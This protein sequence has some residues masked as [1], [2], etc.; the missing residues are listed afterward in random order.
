MKSSAIIKEIRSS[1][2]LSQSEL[3]EKLGVSFATV[4]RWEKGR[5][6]PS[7]IALNAVKS[8]CADSSIDFSQFEGNHYVSSNEI[9]TLYH[10]SKSGI[11]G[12]IAPTS[13]ARCDFGRGFYMGTDRNQ[14]LTLIC[15]YREAKIYTLTMNLSG[16]K[17]LDL[18]VGLDWA[19]LVAYNRGK[20]ETVRH[21]SI[22][23]RFADLSKDC[24]LIIGYIADDR[25]FVVLDRFFNGEITDLAL[26]N[27]LSALQLGRQYVA[28]T[29]KA[30]S[31][32]K[33]LD[34]QEIS[35]DDRDRLKLEG[36]ANR[37]KGIAMAEEIC[38][39]YRREGRFFDEILKAGG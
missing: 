28:L 14:P 7:Q 6:E 4:N 15:N 2:G 37:S 20:M 24:D 34:E 30:C 35:A 23:D 17:I 18:E 22:Y 9:I 27:S 12:P 3:A 5:C 19:L 11:R 25:M 26:I 39:R 8:L 10:G 13:R 38:R 16:L 21:T 36:A 32:I 1:L 29:E 31:Q 33:I